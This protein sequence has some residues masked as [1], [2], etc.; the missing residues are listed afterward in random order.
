M[1]SVVGG[2]QTRHHLSHPGCSAAVGSTLVD[3]NLTP[4]LDA[5]QNAA[6][7]S[8]LRGQAG[9]HQQAVGALIPK[10]MELD[11]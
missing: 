10:H 2:E 3:A 11:P 6:G 1:R 8:A 9:P 4:H 7:R 5:R